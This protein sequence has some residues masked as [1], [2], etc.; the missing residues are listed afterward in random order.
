MW[1]PLMLLVG[2][3]GTNRRILPKPN[4]RK[5]EPNLTKPSTIQKQC[6][7]NFAPK[8]QSYHYAIFCNPVASYYVVHKSGMAP[9]L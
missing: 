5:A 4:Q 8:D 3:G 9:T 1:T 7:P 2:I 6:S